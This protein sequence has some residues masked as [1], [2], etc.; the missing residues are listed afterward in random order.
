MQ[1]DRAVQ[2]EKAIKVKRLVLVAVFAGV[3]RV[4]KRL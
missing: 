4:D 1:L 2:P 3:S